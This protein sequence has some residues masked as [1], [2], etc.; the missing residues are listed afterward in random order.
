MSNKEITLF[1]GD[2]KIITSPEPS[3][4][5]TGRLDIA[6]DLIVGGVITGTVAGD[7]G[8]LSG[9]TDDDHTQYSL[10]VGRSG[11]QILTGG[12]LASNTLTLRSTSNI[13]KGSIILDETT[14]T[15]SSTTGSLKLSGGIGISNTT[16][17]S[18]SINGGTITTA[19]GLAVAKKAYIG[20]DLSVGGNFTVNGTTNIDHGSISG[21]LDDDHTQYTLL[22]GR[23][24]GQILTGGTS[25]TNNL[26]L[27]STSDVSKGSVIF[28]ET[29]STTGSTIGSVRIFGGIAISNNTDASS[30]INGGT[31]T[32]AGGLAVA[33]KVFIGTDLSVEGTTAA[34]SSITGS[35][36]LAGGLGISNTTDAISASNGGTITTAGGLAVA[37]KVYIGTDL[38]VGGTATI[39]TLIGPHSTLTG[40]TSGDDHT[41]YLLLVGR[42]SGQTIV[43][44]TGANQTLTIRSTSNATKGSVYLDETTV[45][46]S[47]TTGSLRLAGSI[48]IANT[49]DAS[50]SINGGTITTAG[51]L[52]VAKKVYIGTDLSVEGS[53]AST[54]STTGSLKLVGGLGISNTTDATSASNGGSITTAGGLAVAKKVFI[55]TDLSVEGSTVSTSSTTG[56]LKLVGGLG[57]SNTT[58]ATSASNGGSITTA[59]GMAVAKKVFIGSSLSVGSTTLLNNY[60]ETR[61]IIAPGNPSVDI[62]R[63]YTD[64]SDSL[65]KSK[66]SS[67]TLTIYQPTNTKGDLLSHNGTTQVRLPVGI[68][69]QIVV[70]DST[71]SSGLKWDYPFKYYLISDQKTIGTNGGTAVQAVWTQRTLNTITAYP[72]GGTLV[73]LSGSDIIL[74]AGSY[75]IYALSPYQGTKNT[76][77]RI[78]NVTGSS[79]LLTGTSINS[80][81]NNKS[82][83]SIIQGIITVGSTTTIR[84]EYNANTGENNIGLGSATGLQVETYSIVEIQVI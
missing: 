50:S 39:T 3:I 10:L 77:T 1:E 14:A 49:E 65:L 61:N 33:K 17:A 80:N 60:Y 22:T 45:S 9:L 19:G 31:I 5:G 66:N 71:Q 46:T 21:L 57:I 2:V 18:S 37:K 12:T 8:G 32:T 40:L 82:V 84:L 79:V 54:S 44:G 55:G 74:S 78:Y 23:T 6:G 26:I 42:N 73:T 7:H 28:D 59:G 4:Y 20:T 75:K 83:Y 36:K 67:G 56:S 43:G 81:D 16:D 62:I 69:K 27:R 15:T 63:F 51:G 58:D 76:A 53:T 30:S 13:T 48:G 34:T 38:N 41:Q 52:A 25:G 35:L 72:S 24:G 11:G 70:A 64:T 29:T 47:S 68:N